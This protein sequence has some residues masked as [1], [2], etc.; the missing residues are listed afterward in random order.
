MFCFL[1]SGSIVIQAI[2][3]KNTMGTASPGKSSGKG[4][5]KGS[6]NAMGMMTQ[7][8]DPTL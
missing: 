1:K 3:G 2:T 6:V 8:N 7:A 5:D 4:C